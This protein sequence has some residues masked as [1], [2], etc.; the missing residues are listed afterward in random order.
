M[1]L[2][3]FVNILPELRTQYSIDM[4]ATSMSNL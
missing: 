1:S 2:P 4:R 3:K